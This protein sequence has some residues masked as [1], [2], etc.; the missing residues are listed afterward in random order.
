V[1]HAFPGGYNTA[2]NLPVE[3]YAKTV[4]RQ[5]SIVVGQFFKSPFPDFG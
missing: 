5:G 2:G 3:W 4:E 1:N